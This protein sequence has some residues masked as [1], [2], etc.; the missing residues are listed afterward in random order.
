MHVITNASEDI[1]FIEIKKHFKSYGNIL[2]TNGSANSPL[3]SQMG[4]QAC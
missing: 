2:E 3:K 1:C 4:Q